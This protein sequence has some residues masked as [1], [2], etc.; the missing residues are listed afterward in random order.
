MTLEV[1]FDFWRAQE[2]ADCQKSIRVIGDINRVGLRKQI[3][4]SEFPWERS[5]L[6]EDARAATSP[7]RAVKVR[8][9]RTG[10]KRDRYR[11]ATGRFI[12]SLPYERTVL[13]IL[14]DQNQLRPESA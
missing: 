5:S 11:L 12:R 13:V 3:D 7:A 2:I 9:A 1:G 10:L 4:A 14:T 6:A 8:F